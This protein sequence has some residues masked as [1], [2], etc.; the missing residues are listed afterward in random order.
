MSTYINFSDKA[1]AVEIFSIRRK[2][3]IGSAKLDSFIPRTILEWSLNSEW[4]LLKNMRKNTKG[5][6]LL[7]IVGVVGLAVALIVGILVWRA[8]LKW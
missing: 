8:I 7:I 5:S 2:M 1:I 4:M 6:T 3:T